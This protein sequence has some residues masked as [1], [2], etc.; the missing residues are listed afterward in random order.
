MTAGPDATRI[1]VV[2]DVD[3]GVDDALAL[4]VLAR[5]TQ[6]RLK[7]VTCVAGNT[8][9]SQVVRNT[10]NV[11]ELAGAGH[12]P[13]GRGAERP[14]INKLRTAHGFHG[15]NGLGGIE[16]PE[17]PRPASPLSAIELIRWAVEDS[18]EPVTLLAVG[19]LT[20]VALFIRAYPQHASAL[21][22]IVFMGGSASL[23]NASAV[24]EFNAWHD[25]E[26][27]AIVLDS[28]IPT[29]MYGLDVFYAANLIDTEY[30]PLLDSDDPGTRLVGSLLQY[31]AARESEDDR[32]NAGATIGDAGAACLVANPQ[33]ASLNEYPVS[34]VLA[35]DSRGQTV[36][37]RRSRPGESELH[38]LS[39]SARRIH[40][41]TA[42][43][44]QLMRQTF[45]ASVTEGATQ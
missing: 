29:T 42:V 38:G 23:G 7:A 13:V 16:L 24:A 12:V 34:V 36:V 44:A 6:I 39:G 37:D 26:A 22:R 18:D 8:D 11:L 31:A 30:L 45:L 14:L 17:S 35:G 3:T 33:V 5:S 19:P 9:V 10:L 27:L 43:D 4:F 28:G 41:A 15:V 2:A 20:N 32:T 40:V 21:G 25:P 1:S